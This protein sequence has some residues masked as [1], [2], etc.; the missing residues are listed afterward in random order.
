MSRLTAGYLKILAAATLALSMI[1]PAHAAP[2][3]L[4]DAQLT[5][6]WALS[7]AKG[8]HVVVVDQVTNALGLTANGSQI[9]VFQLSFK[10]TSTGITHKFDPLNDGRGYL[11]MVGMPDGVSYRCYWVDKDLVLI[12]A[13][14]FRPGQTSAP[15][16]TPIASTQLDEE[17]KIWAL[18]A[19]DVR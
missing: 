11:I 7:A 6:L 12:S 2:K 9:D 16:P 3:P 1:A 14:D 8:V 4:S 17:W 15:I 13:L 19:N 5:R 10:Q 18:L